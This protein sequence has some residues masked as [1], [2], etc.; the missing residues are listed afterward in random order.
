MGAGLRGRAD[1]GD[2]PMIR[3]VLHQYA[4]NLLYAIDALVNTLIGGDPRETIS[5]RL[6][7]GQLAGKPVHSAIAAAVDWFFRVF[8]SE[9]EHC[10]NSIVIAH[11]T[12][13]ISSVIQ[14]HRQ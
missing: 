13:S 5:S 7:K 8:F 9:P 3:K 14:R 12:Y 6:G 10:K 4:F 2:G 11:D 1:S